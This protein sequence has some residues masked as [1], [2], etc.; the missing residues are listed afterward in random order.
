MKI[1]YP[2]CILMTFCLC[3]PAHASRDSATK[4]D[5]MLQARLIATDLAILKKDK[6]NDKKIKLL[7]SFATEKKYDCYPEPQTPGSV[8]EENCWSSCAKDNMSTDYCNSLCGTNTQ[9]GE[10][11][12]WTKCSNDN[13]S[14]NYCNSLCGTD[15]AGGVASC[16]ESCTSD[17]FSS[18]YC[19]TLCD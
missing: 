7:K 8:G 12:C 17:N 19:K 6:S 2:L 4:R 14:S 10:E 16:W 3:L 1:F 18:T 11:S 13:Y 9:V 5:H 15:T